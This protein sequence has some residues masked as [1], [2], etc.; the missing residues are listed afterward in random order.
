MLPF[1]F[2][3]FNITMCILS[4]CNWQSSNDKLGFY[5]NIYSMDIVGFQPST[6]IVHKDNVYVS[7][8]SLFVS[9]MF[10]VILNL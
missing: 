7:I 4:A 2:P 8:K 6:Y 3:P 10:F 5:A 9:V 1:V